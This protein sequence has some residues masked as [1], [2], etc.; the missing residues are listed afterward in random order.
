MASYVLTDVANDLWVESFSLSSNDVGGGATPWS[1]TKRALKGGRRDGVDLVRLDNGAFSIDIVP[2]RGMSLRQGHYNGNRVGWTS[3]VTDGPVNPKFV[4][5]QNWGGLGWLEGY[6][7]ML[8]RC[9][10]ENMGSP[11]QE[12]ATSAD[13]TSLS[14]IHI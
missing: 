6:D 1:V 7:E 9:G 14:L 2:T 5:L 12:T 4:N 13:G 11:Y 8:V 3:A 10:L